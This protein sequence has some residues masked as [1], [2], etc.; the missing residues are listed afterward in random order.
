MKAAPEFEQD[1]LP[2]VSRSDQRVDLWR[3]PVGLAW[4]A[5][6]C[7]CIGGRPSL[8]EAVNETK[9][10]NGKRK[11]SF[12]IRRK[13]GMLLSGIEV[14]VCR[15]SFA[16][17]GG[18]SRTRFDLGLWVPDTARAFATQGHSLLQ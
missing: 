15:L 6:H 11:S 18:T 12:R 5:S 17:F 13:G 2:W 1:F 10:N 8:V 16:I 4:G 9:P 3:V 7:P 14:S